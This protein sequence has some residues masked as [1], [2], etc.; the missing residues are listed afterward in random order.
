MK[1][2]RF[3]IIVSTLIIG[4]LIILGSFLVI[5]DIQKGI[6]EGE[7]RDKGLLLSNHLRLELTTPVLTNELMEV[8]GYIDNLKNSYTDIEYIFVTDSDGIVLVHTFDNGFPIA[9]QNMSKP[10]N[11]Q[12]EFIFYTDR[13]IIHEFD[14]PLLENIGYVHMGLSETRVRK[15]IQESS[16][17]L[18][19]LAVLA[20]I[21]WGVF[22]FFTGRWLTEPVFR[23]TE[24]AKRINKGIL[25]Q[26]I[27]VTSNDELGE[28]AVTFNDMSKSLEQKIKD[29]VTSKEHVETAQKYLETL[30]NSIDDGIIVL[31]TKH[32]IIRVNKSM[33]KMM[34]LAEEQLTGKICHEVIFG[35]P[36][37]PYENENCPINEMLRTKNPMRMLHEAVVNGGKKILEIN[38]SMLSNRG[39]V[40]IILVLRDITQQKALEAEII[41]RNRELTALN[42][43]SKN[44][45]ESFELDN[46]LLKTLENLLKLTDM[47]HG[48][49]YLLDEKSGDFVLKINTG[50]ES[51]SPLPKVLPRIIN[52]SGI[53]TIDDPRKNPWIKSVESQNVDVSFLGIPLKLKD[54]VFGVITLRSSKQHKFSGK[55]KELFSAI[56]NRAGYCHREY[57]IL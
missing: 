27:E 2:L 44:I 14:A 18:L 3:K 29:L 49:A 9:L 52:T 30:F 50:N 17:R 28:L 39:E 57:N 16:E 7:F 6:I 38:S 25:D 4:L 41:F 32:E 22:I 51:T 10:S 47:E 36:P 34:N 55:D 48:E 54:R 37:S 31:N 24:G 19:L 5:Q 15:Q 13:G 45:S 21:L 23:L 46:I 8:K 11:I 33:L 20:F 53:L 12:K 42:E 1:S 26:K 56:G 43:I 40:N 35:L